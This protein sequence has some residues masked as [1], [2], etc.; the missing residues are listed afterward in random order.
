MYL[1][2]VEDLSLRQ[3][4]A[5]LHITEMHVTPIAMSD[6]PLLNAAGLHAP[7]ALRIIVELVSD[8]GVSG[9]SEI[10]GSQAVG[11]ALSDAR[12]VL[13]GRDPYDLNRLMT[14]LTE[15]F[16]TDSADT[17]GSAPW[18]QRRLVHIFSAVEVACLDMVGKDMGRP[19]VDLLGGAAREKAGRHRVA[20]RAAAAGRHY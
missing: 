19:V 10:P 7:Y 3:G 4:A 17:R 12:E 6:P 16:G 15:R 2:T 14:V 13:I 1:T 18:D 8:C 5:L 20:A 9:L 11:E